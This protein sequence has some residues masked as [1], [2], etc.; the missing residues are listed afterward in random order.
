MSEEEFNKK[1]NELNSF[2]AIEREKIDK[3]YYLKLHNLKLEYFKKQRELKTY[4]E[5]K[6]L[7]FVKTTAAPMGLKI[8]FK[9]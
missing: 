3:E 9:S 2:L 6:E 7:A 4:F 8:I 5:K 1:I